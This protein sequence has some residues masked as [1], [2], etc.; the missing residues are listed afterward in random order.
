MLP[1]N[2][3]RLARE[4]FSGWGETAPSVRDLHNS[5]IGPRIDK[6]FKPYAQEGATSDDRL[7]AIRLV[8]NLVRGTNWTAMALHGGGNTEA[9]RLMAMRHVDWRKLIKLAEATCGIEKDDTEALKMLAERAGKI[10]V[11]PK[12]FKMK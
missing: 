7:R 12:A 2:G 11:G 3:V 9:A 10:D 5:E 4:I 6:Y 1:F 8:E